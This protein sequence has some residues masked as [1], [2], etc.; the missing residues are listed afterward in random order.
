[1]IGT[2]LRQRLAAGD[3]L[4][5][6]N[7]NHVSSGLA[8]RL[9]EVGA[10]LIFID[11][12]HG[13]A[14]FDEAR[15]MARAARSGGGGA[16]LRPDS[17]QRSLITRYLN[18]GVDGVMVPLVNTAQQ[19]RTIVGTVRYACPSDY[20]KKLVV[21]MVETVEAIGNLDEILAVEG[22]DVFFVGPGDLSQS[23][24]YMPAVP[25]GQSRPRDVLDLVETT[26]TRIRAAGKVA[27]TL[28]IE[29]DIAHWSRFGAQLLYCHVDPFLRDKIETMH[30]LAKQK[31]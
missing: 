1:M 30:A 21:A 3:H 2:T 6:V 12:E 16:I 9:P 13:T 22:I 18:A 31:N 26:L 24:G 11:C 15:E 4:L 29:E 8:A 23:M 25:R 19:A 20:E 5:M 14:S 27:G 10:D 7:P 17:H 28:V